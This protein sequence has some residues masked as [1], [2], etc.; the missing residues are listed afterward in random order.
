V[1]SPAESDVLGRLK[2]ALVD[3][4]GP[5]LV[6][7]ILFGSR[8]RGRGR[9]DSDLDV[10][11]GVR[12]LSRSERGDVIDLAADLGVESGL[13]LSPL[14]LAVDADGQPPQAARAIHERALREEFLSAVERV[15]TGAAPPSVSGG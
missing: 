11:V 6:E 1:L 4:F 3:L 12:G 14:V 9:D 13:I 2:A 7:L 8:A 15:L 10:I 5:R